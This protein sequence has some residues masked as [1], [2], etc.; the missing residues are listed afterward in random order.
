MKLSTRK[1]SIVFILFAFVV[2]ATGQYFLQPYMIK[3]IPPPGSDPY[4][5]YWAQVD[6]LENLGLTESANKVVGKITELAER[7]KN[8]IQLI[9]AF[10]HSAKYR[11]ILEEESFNTNMARLDEMIK[12]SSTPVQQLLYSIKGEVIWNKYLATMWQVNQRTP[13]E[14]DKETDMDKWDSKR[15]AR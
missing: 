10:F 9:K 11:D 1:S 8:S 15:F 6:S 14:G 2:C 7:D 12:N 5:A 13:I 4:K 3:K